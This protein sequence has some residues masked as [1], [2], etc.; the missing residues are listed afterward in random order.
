MG[1]IS[2]GQSHLAHTWTEEG[3]FLVTWRPEG[4]VQ[5]DPQ[6]EGREMWASRP[7]GDQVAT[8]QGLAD[9]GQEGGGRRVGAGSLLPPAVCPPPGELPVCAAHSLWRRHVHHLRE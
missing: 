1:G 9:G 2:C 3:D 7:P 5:A 8:L 4:R 6:Q